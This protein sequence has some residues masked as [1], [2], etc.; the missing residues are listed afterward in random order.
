VP[1]PLLHADL[2]RIN[3]SERTGG[4]QLSPL[5]EGTLALIE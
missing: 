3:D 2:Y 1:F 4:N 5:P